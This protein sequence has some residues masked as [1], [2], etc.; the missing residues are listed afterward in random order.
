MLLTDGNI[1]KFKIL[2]DPLFVN[3]D[4]T[5]FYN[6]VSANMMIANIK[7]NNIS[8]ALFKTNVDT[9]YFVVREDKLTGVNRLQCSK[10]FLLFNKEKLKTIYFNDKIYGDFY[11]PDYA[12]KNKTKLLLDQF[13]A[14]GE[15]IKNTTTPDVKK[16]KDKIKM[17]SLLSDKD[18]EEFFKE[19]QNQNI[20]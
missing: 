12:S 13:L 18:I 17:V 10:F 6:Q 20:S 11:F 5:G 3:A 16:I 15:F 2:K 14:E 7:D 4:N 9:Y 1:S 8:K 19:Q